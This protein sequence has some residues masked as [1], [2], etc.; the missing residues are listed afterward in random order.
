LYD[1]A[2]AYRVARTKHGSKRRTIDARN[3]SEDVDLKTVIYTN[4]PVREEALMVDSEIKSRKHSSQIC[5]TWDIQIP[6]RKDTLPEADLVYVVTPVLFS[7]TSFELANRM[8]SLEEWSRSS[9]V[10]NPFVSLLRSTKA[11]FTQYCERLGI[12]H[13]KT[14]VTEDPQKA[15]DFGMNLFDEGQQIVMKPVARGEGAGIRLLKPMKRDTFL[16]YL[17]WYSTEYGDRV[18]Y[19]QE[20]VEN[21][22]YDVRFFIINGKVMGRMK[23]MSFNDFR[24]N[25]AQG[26]A[27]EIYQVEEFDKLALDAAKAMGAEIAGV[28]IMPTREKAVA[29]EVNLYPGFKGLIETT[30]VPVHKLIVD[31]FET[32]T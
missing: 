9:V 11:H 29:L 8:V 19:M 3:L 21:M 4:N 5:A 25:L 26:G 32:L 31:Y 10:V 20:Y 18:F 1:C 17:L 13:P 22:G 23:R 15:L 27:S 6:F 7:G 30:G 14:L 12:P 24:Y 2:A 28:D 16:R